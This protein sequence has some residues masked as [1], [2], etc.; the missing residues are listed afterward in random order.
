MPILRLLVCDDSPTNSSRE[1][2]A[3]GMKMQVGMFTILPKAFKEL[4]LRAKN[5]QGLDLRHIAF[6]AESC[7]SLQTRAFTEFED[8]G[9]RLKIACKMEGSWRN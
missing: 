4:G 5:I 9:R 1:S 6:M 7:Q 8:T 2:A 3:R